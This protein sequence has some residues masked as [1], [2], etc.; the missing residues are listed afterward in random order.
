ML[1][2]YHGAVYEA[3]VELEKAWGHGARVRDLAETLAFPEVTVCKYLEELEVVGLVIWEPARDV[4]WF[5]RGLPVL[6][7]VG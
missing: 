1:L 6:G 7:A 4:A 2:E 3:V 5:E